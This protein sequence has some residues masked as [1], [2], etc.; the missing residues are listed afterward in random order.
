MTRLT[1]AVLAVLIAAVVALTLALVDVRERLRENEAE[2][3]RL[4]SCV[5]IL[6]RNQGTP[7]RESIQGCPI[8]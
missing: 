5:D 2:V 8:P 4:Q 1:G 7:P 6:E 3:S